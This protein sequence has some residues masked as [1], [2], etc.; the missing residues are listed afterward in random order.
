MCYVLKCINKTFSL[1]A[2]CSDIRNHFHVNRRL[3]LCYMLK[4]HSYACYYKFSNLA[5]CEDI[6]YDIVSQ[7]GTQTHFCSTP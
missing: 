4:A 2:G 3:A 1:L 7:H 5:E 6:S